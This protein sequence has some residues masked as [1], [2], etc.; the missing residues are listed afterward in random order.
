M[1]V[2]GYISVVVFLVSALGVQAQRD[3][4]GYPKVNAYLSADSVMIGD[5]FRLSVEIDKDMVQVIQFPAFE[6][7]RIGQAIEILE[8][9][10][11]DTLSKEGRRIRL[12]RDY[13]LT[14]FDEGIYSLGKFPVLYVDKNIVDT[15]WSADSLMLKVVTFDID[16]LSQTIFDIK[17]PMP[18]PFK[19]AEIT[20][21]VMWACGIVFVVSF[22][23]LWLDSRRRERRGR[24]P[25]KAALPPHVVAIRE[26]EK[27]H[28]QK[29]WQSGRHKQYYTRL[30]DIVREYIDERYGVPAME[31]TSEEIL[32]SLRDGNLPP[33]ARKR[34]EELLRTADF[35]KFA[36]FI[37]G[38][39]ENEAVYN[40]AYYFVEDT[41]EM[42]I[43]TENTDTKD[44]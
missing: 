3:S 5:Q 18:A 21:Y 2:A 20:G 13:L 8:E 27:V 7:G 42:P 10:A 9:G 43:E 32:D 23:L 12:K 33:A 16:T 44:A 30:T 37:P 41:K 15:L 28:A 29:M 25:R 6:K 11:L 40:D 4:S 35:V 1:K 19:P 34:L 31:M 14:T 24:G 17:A 36:K 39:E 22:L 26:L 38:M